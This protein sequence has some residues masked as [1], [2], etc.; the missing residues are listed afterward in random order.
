M[1]TYT[2]CLTLI[3]LILLTVNSYADQRIADSQKKWAEKYKKH[4][5]I[6]P[7]AQVLVNTDQEPD[8]TEGFT[9]LYNGEN[10]KGWV[11]RG[12][13]STFEARGE[14]IVGTCVPTSPSTY[15]S[16]VKDDYQDF[17]FSVEVKWEVDGN[18]GII[19]RGQSK[20]VSGKYQKVFGPQ[21]EMEDMKKQRFWS[22]GIYGQ[23]A[24]GWQYPMWLEA[25]EKVRNAIDYTQWNRMT[26]EAKG[27]TVK[28]WI[29]GVP[30]AHWLTE[31]YQQ[32][33][34]SLQVHSGS[35]GTFLFRNIKVKEL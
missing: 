3:A 20:P 17:I 14:T 32:G 31:K 24:G 35:K 13:Y 15:L 4:K 30:A 25:H 5:H 1:K 26:I 22:G 7:L 34:F 6:V 19:F 10:L 9:S 11:P 27:N 33:F 21:A 23:G 29:N 12:G 18:T 8:L 16:T 28:T 2:S